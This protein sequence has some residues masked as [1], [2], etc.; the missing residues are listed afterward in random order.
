MPSEKGG[1]ASDGINGADSKAQT[2]CIISDNGSHSRSN[3]WQKNI[4]A[5][6]AC[7]AKSGSFRLRPILY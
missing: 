7:A 4:S 3:T 6:T 2:D 5:R 1:A